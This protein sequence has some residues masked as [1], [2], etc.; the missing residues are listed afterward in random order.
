MFTILK[1][2]ENKG[3]SVSR[4]EFRGYTPPSH[5]Q[6]S[7]WVWHFLC[8]RRLQHSTV[9]WRLPREELNSNSSL[10]LSFML[11]GSGCFLA[12]ILAQA[13]SFYVPNNRVSRQNRILFFSS[14]DN[15]WARSSTSD[16][17]SSSSCPLRSRPTLATPQVPLSSA[18]MV[19]IVGKMMSVSFCLE[20]SIAS[21]SRAVNEP[22]NANPLADC[23]QWSTL[24]RMFIRPITC[25]PSFHYQRSVALLY[26]PLNQKKYHTAFF[27]QFPKECSEILYDTVLNFIF[28]NALFNYS[29][30]QCF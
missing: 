23:P 22:R 6:F 24:P 12:A 20:T 26:S 19:C 25:P 21:F 2:T 1:F 11:R 17:N 7:P 16:P 15:A 28:D 3:A 13:V 30:P 5:L 8:W 4:L 29:Q 14:W 18:A 10:F 9:P 27:K